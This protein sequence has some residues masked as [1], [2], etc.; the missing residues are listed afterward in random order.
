MPRALSADEIEAF[1]TRLVDAATHLFAT[2]GR[3]G[4]S[5]R[6]LAAVLG[7]SAMTPYRY[8]QDK[9]EILAAVRTCAFDR[10]AERLE[11]AYEQAGGD[12]RARSSA[13]GRAYVDFAFDNPEAYRLMFDLAEGGEEERYPELTR[14][15]ERA[16][17][18]MSRHLGPLIDEGLIEGDS[19]LIGHMLW[20]TVHG[21]IE[22]KLAGKL[23]VGC[24]FERL[25]SE[26][27]TAILR[28]LAP[29]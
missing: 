14:A 27:T 1:R 28:G 2:R 5:M 12:A 9:D 3:D 17:A 8:F 29:G 4:V 20:A 6:E 10:F 11:G 22:L 7:V 13:V 24:D 18:T 26:A 25:V 23:A 15:T 16:R 21:A 19:E